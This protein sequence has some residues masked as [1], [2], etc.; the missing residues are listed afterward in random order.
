MIWN[1]YL[2][3]GM[4]YVPTV[5]RT[6]SG[7]YLD[8]EPVGVA[9]ATDADAVRKVV[10]SAIERGNP[11]IPTPARGAFPKP[12][13]LRH[14]GMQS[15]SEFERATS[16]LAVAHRD[17]RFRIIPRRKGDEGG[18]EDDVS[19]TEVLDPSAGSEDVAR[20]IVVLI[21]SHR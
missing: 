7:L 18:W 21:G 20:R 6:E 14:A 17:G 15:W 5:A 2:R 13:V 1:V 19:A 10:R 8:V 11:A 12:V 16:S 9:A 3:R 4:L